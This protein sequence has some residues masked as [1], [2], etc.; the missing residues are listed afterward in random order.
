MLFLHYLSYWIVFVYIFLF[1]LCFGSRWCTLLS[2]CWQLRSPHQGITVHYCT[3]Q[4]NTVLYSTILYSTVHYCTLQYTTVLY[5][6]LQYATVLLSL[7]LNQL[8]PSRFMLI[9]ILYTTVHNYTQLYTTVHNCTPLYCTLLS[10]C[11]VHN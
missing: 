1:R 3:L 7:N 4:Y 2:Q 5:S 9:C 8:R 6:T 10:H 11:L